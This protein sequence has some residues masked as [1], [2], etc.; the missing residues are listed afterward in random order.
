MG[1]EIEAMYK[2]A[3]SYKGTKNT[4]TANK[5]SEMPTN[6]DSIS[7]PAGNLGQNMEWK[8][9]FFSANSDPY[10]ISVAA[11]EQE[12]GAHEKKPSSDSD[13]EPEYDDYI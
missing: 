4:G 11:M 10:S 12:Y 2:H 3:K 5:N 13:S 8:N 1:P 9:A 6:T 7:I